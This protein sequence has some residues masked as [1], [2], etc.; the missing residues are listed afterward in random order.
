M[1]RPLSPRHYPAFP[2]RLQPALLTLAA[3]ALCACTATLAACTAAVD[4]S[5]SADDLQQAQYSSVIFHEMREGEAFNQAVHQYIEN[6]AHDPTAGYRVFQSGDRWLIYFETG[7]Y[8]TSYHQGDT[9]DLHQPFPGSV[10]FAVDVAAGQAQQLQ[11]RDLQS[12][13]FDIHAAKPLLA[14][15]LFLEADGIQ[16]GPG[17]AYRVGLFPNRVVILRGDARDVFT[18]RPNGALPLDKLRFKPAPRHYDAE[19]Q[20]SFRRRE[21]VPA[22]VLPA[23]LPPRLKQKVID[24]VILRSPYAGPRFGPKAL[25]RDAN[26][27]QYEPLTDVE[28]QYTASSGSSYE[29]L[30]RNLARIEAIRPAG[31]TPAW[32]LRFDAFL[33]RDENGNTRTVDVGAGEVPAPRLIGELFLAGQGRSLS[34]AATD[35]DRAIHVRMSAEDVFDESALIRA[36]VDFDRHDFRV[37]F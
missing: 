33:L 31:E 17:K 16:T 2:P 6:G 22:A 21:A 34:L 4:A 10:W 1:P 3:A 15:G 37:P 30:R 20:L 32:E 23:S 29:N 26:S 19:Y 35:K 27:G 18:L 24:L 7:V 36:G 9:S 25:V 28:F 14:D 8:T 5:P 11:D 12:D 13:G